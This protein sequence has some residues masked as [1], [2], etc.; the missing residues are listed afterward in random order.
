MDRPYAKAAVYGV[1]LALYAGVRPGG[2]YALKP[3][4]RPEKMLCNVAATIDGIEEAS[5]MGGAVRRGE[6]GAPSLGIGKFLARLVREAFRWC[7]VAYPALVAPIAVLTMAMGYADSESVVEDAAK[8]KRFLESLLT[9][10]PWSEARGF[11]EA[12]RSVHRDDMYEHASSAGVSPLPYAVGQAS[13]AEVFR[14]LGSR[15]PSFAAIDPREFPLPGMV[16][17]L[18]ELHRKFGDAGVALGALY[19]QLVEPK[20]P[21]DVREEAKRLASGSIAE[22]D[23]FRKLVELDAKLARRGVRLDEYSELLALVAYAGALEGVR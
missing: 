14:V 16:K 21:G 7:G 11:L 2:V 22:R 3:G 12:L 18:V 4:A 5:D 17:A 1:G 23:A 10:A 6:V 9:S 8:V 19:L 15:W 20:L 13:M